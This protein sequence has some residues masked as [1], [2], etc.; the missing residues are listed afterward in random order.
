MMLMVNFPRRNPRLPGNPQIR[1]PGLWNPPSTV[2]T[3]FTLAIPERMTTR[4]SRKGG[5]PQTIGGC[6]SSLGSS[7]DSSGL[8]RSPSRTLLRYH[9]SFPSRPT[10]RSERLVCAAPAHPRTISLYSSSAHNNVTEPVYK[11]THGTLPTP[12]NPTIT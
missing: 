3:G 12:I 7:P 1:P 8:R 2:P 4:L 11:S 9:G 5:Y 10:P 6:H